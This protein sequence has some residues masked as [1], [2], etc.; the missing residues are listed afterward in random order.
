MKKQENLTQAK[1]IGEMLIQVAQDITADN[2]RTI[3]DKLNISMATLSKYLGGKVA[4]SD[5]GASILVCCRAIIKKRERQ[6]KAA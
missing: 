3:I 4:D 1:R 6:I 2:R 5:T